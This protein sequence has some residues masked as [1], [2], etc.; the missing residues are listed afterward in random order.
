MNVYVEQ[1]A[2][3][4]MCSSSFMR[5]GRTFGWQ[6]GARCVCL[7]AYIGGTS[8]YTHERGNNAFHDFLR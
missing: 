1:T 6:I 5:R 7:L 4:S 3:K 2:A 8:I